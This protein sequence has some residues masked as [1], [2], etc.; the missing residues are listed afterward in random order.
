MNIDNKKQSAQLVLSLMDLTSLNESD[1]DQTIVDLCHQAKTSFGEPAAVCV[2]PQFIQVAKQTLA[3]LGI[4]HVK[5]ATVTNFPHGHSDIQNAVLE[6]EQAVANGADEVDVVFPYRALIAGDAQVGFD[7]VQACKKVCADNNV[8]LKV[9]I[10]SGELK[11]DELIR[12]AST[13]A[14]QAGADFIKTS[15]GKVPVNATLSAAEIMLKVIVELNAQDKVGFKAAGGVRTVDEA[16]QYLALAASIISP[17]YLTTERF[18]FGASGLLNNL[19][20][21]LKNETITPNNTAY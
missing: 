17:D 19:L 12:K 10:E 8:L 13:I 6:T 20:A 18:R 5:V 2:Y 7:L 9:I 16:Q 11:S 1:V 21:T 4:S 3:S 15:T 14:I